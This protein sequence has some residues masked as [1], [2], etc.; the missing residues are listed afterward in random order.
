MMA[1]SENKN[2]SLSSSTTK[3][4]TTTSKTGKSAISPLTVD[5]LKKVIR[6]STP[7]QDWPKKKPPKHTPGQFGYFVSR[8]L[9]M[10]SAVE[11]YNEVF[12]GI[13]IGDQ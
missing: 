7:S 10:F 12:P 9:S 11:R 3:S 6:E 5:D 4:E 2:T 13:I 1:T 8:D